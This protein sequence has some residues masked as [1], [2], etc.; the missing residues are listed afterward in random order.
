[1]TSWPADHVER[2]PV[3]G[4][5]PYARNARTH[6]AEQV[7]QLAASIKEWGWTSPALVDEQGRLIAGHGRV[8][9]AKELGLDQIPVMVARG[10]TEAQIQAYRLADNQLAINAGWDADLL[11][12][13]LG[14]LK[15]AG[16]DLDLVGFVDV[17]LAGFMADRNDGLTDPDEVPAPPADPVSR[18]GDVW[19]LG[20][21]RL[22]CGDS[23][24]RET[25]ERVLGGVKPH[26]MVTDPPYGVSYD[27]DWRNRKDRAN[28][29]PYGASAI[30]TVQNDERA[31]WGEAYALFPGDVA[32]VWHQAGA[33]QVEFF[34]SLVASGFEVRMQIIWAKSQFPI[35]RG[36]YHVQHEPC[37]YAVRKGK[38]AHWAGDRKQTTVWQIDKPR[39]SETG[40]ST[41]KPVECMRRPIENNSSPGQAV[42]E[43]FAGS[44]TTGIAA[45]MTGRAC[46]AIEL[47]PAYVDVG[48]LRWQGFTGELAIHEETGRTFA[49]LAADRGVVLP[50]RQLAGAA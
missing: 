42:Y 32:Y 9:A 17:E 21:H 19:V 34:Q 26:L 35:G 4:L 20:R 39:K 30:G 15:L 13:E 37:W 45:E 41:Q 8:L 27:P 18:L 11:K 33:K 5:V 31:D 12:V 29:R 50:D 23:T 10:W 49:E 36:N 1:M 46:L 44:F 6:S 16:F 2:R 47:N 24:Q 40:H 43:P 22:A 14:D 38:T 48:V 25:V 7:K 3:A 28:G